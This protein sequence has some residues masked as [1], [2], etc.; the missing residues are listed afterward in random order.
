MHHVVA[1]ELILCAKS[2]SNFFLPTGKLKLDRA[3][4]FSF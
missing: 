1:L 3:D 2:Q 4:S